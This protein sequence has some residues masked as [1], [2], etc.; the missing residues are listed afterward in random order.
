MS[1]T[2]GPIIFDLNG[3][4]LSQ[5]EQE[6]LR[7][8]LIGGVILFSRNYASPEQMVHLTQSIRAASK[9]PVLITVDHEGGR[10][11]RFHAGFTRLPSMAAIGN[12]Y[13]E[14]PEPALHFAR[15]CGWLMAAELLAVGVDLS[16]APVLDLD[17]GL[18]PA[19]GD[20]AF[21]KDP[22]NIVLL[23][24][25]LTQGMREAGMAAVGKHFP[26]H[27]SVS[28]DSHLAMP[29]DERRF[30]QIAQ[31][32]LIPFVKMIQS[33]IQGIMAAHIIFPEVDP[34]PVGFSHYWLH[35]VLRTQLMF[36]GLVFSDALDMKGAMIAGDFA[37]RTQAALEAGC[38]MVLLCNNR[39]G[40]IQ[41]LDRL[42]QSFLLEEQKLVMVRGDFSRVPRDLKQSSEWIKKSTDF[43]QLSDEYKVNI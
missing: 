22:N 23:A 36:S 34:M 31:D 32:D 2:V 17:K 12:L 16:F 20:R 8:P 24:Q 25:A 30:D 40:L 18:N 4:E 10:V 9:N 37:E 19:I 7:H 3:H 33:T 39:E 42:P 27:G 14:A 38:D 43:K 28:V 6:L 41:T 21:H 5:E 35:D 26:G 15:L 11:Q 13:N 1:H 29:I